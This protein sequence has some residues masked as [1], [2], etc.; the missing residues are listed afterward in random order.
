LVF[1]GYLVQQKHLAWW[2]TFLCAALGSIGGVT[3]GYA[4]GHF[5]G[6]HLLQTY[7]PKLHVTAERLERVH[8]WYRRV[9]KWGLAVGYFIPGVRH[10]NGLLAG[11]S[12][13]EFPVFA[14]FAYTGGL[15]WTAAFIL[16]GMLLGEGW[17]RASEQG[18][19]VLLVAT[20]VLA[21]GALLW[22]VLRSRR[23]KPER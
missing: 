3:V 8:A 19:A 20:G 7:G 22:V 13:L 1:Y 16:A 12:K 15:V 9:G 4:L 17:S 10:L 5:F 14:L 6:L 18:R 11:S 23:R 2:P 21:A